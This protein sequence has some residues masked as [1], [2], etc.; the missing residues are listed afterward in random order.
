MVPC[1]HIFLSPQLG[2]KFSR[3]LIQHPGL[4]GIIKKAGPVVISFFSSAVSFDLH[5]S[6]SDRIAP[7]FKLCS[8]GRS[9]PM[10]FK[11]FTTGLPQTPP[12]SP[13]CLPMQPTHQGFLFLCV[14]YRIFSLCLEF[15][16]SPLCLP[17]S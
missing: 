16:F 17:N 7:Q 11:A 9:V 10:W 5:F 15:P 12:W 1:T 13:Q 2:C 8:N 6:Q 4:L 3:L 14:S